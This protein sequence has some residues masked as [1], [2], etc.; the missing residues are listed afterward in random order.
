MG[1]SVAIVILNWNGKTLLEKFLK[2]VT[3]SEYDNLQIIVADNASTDDSLDY[4][5]N[6]FPDVRLIQN[7]ENFGFAEGYNQ[8]LK[9]VD[10]DYFVLLNSDVEVPKNWIRPVIDLMENDDK[11]AVA[12]PKV[13][14]QK[15]K[16]SFEYAG[17]AGGFIDSFGFTFCRGRVFDNLE[18]DLQQYNQDIPVFWASGAAFFIKSSAWTLAKG[19]DGDLFAHMEEIDLCWRLK[20]KGYK[21]MVCT[22]S[23]VYH[24]GGGT[25]DASSPFKNYLNFRNNLIIM[26][27]NLPFSQAYLK[28]FIRLWFDLAAWFQF[29]LKGKMDF[30]FAINKAHFHFFKSSFKTFSKRESHQ[31]ALDKHDGVYQGSVVYQ[32]FIRK[33]KY[34]NELFN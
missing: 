16:N 9:Q 8:A 3:E 23:Q 10:A 30:A 1:K 18:L 19:F 11:I 15:Q 20:N 13:L 5:K 14:W 27:K 4:L 29:A 17:A 21:V 32:Y 34:F 31:L 28:I 2:S 24:V 7:K 26:Y 22:S 12:Q 25:L 6:Y 33:K